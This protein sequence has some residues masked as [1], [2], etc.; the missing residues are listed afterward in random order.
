MTDNKEREP[1]GYFKIDLKLPSLNDVIGE[2]R[3]CKYTGASLKKNIEKQIAAYI[4]VAV[5]KKT[6]RHVDEPVVVVIRWHEKDK[7]RDVDNVESGNK[8][9]LD[10]LVKNGILN[11]DNRRWVKQIY[12]KLIDDTETY[13]E[14]WL[15]PYDKE[16]D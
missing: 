16:R 13:V 15:V 3:G 14:V 11:N 12:P 4:R 8:F 7:R 10:A 1:L 5:A 9:I 6:L 2:N